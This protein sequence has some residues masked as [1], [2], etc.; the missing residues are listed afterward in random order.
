MA[1]KRQA[2]AVEHDGVLSIQ[3]L[4]DV[5]IRYDG[6]LVP[7]K[8]PPR[9]LPLLA[10]LLLHRQETV[11]RER[12][13]AQLWPDDHETDARANL[14]RHVHYLLKVLPEEGGPWLHI[15]RRT[16]SWNDTLPQWIDIDA[17]E[18]AGASEDTLDEAIELYRDDLLPTCYDDW[19]YYERERLRS[20]QI[21]NLERAIARAKQNADRPSML[22][23]AQRLLAMDPWREDVMRELLAT[24]QALGDRAGALAEFERFAQRLQD[25]LG[26]E[27]M[28]ETLAVLNDTA[29]LAPALPAQ[30]TI[31]G[32]E[33]EMERLRAWWS[34]A[35]R[36]GCSVALIGGEAGIGKSALL[37]VLAGLAAS[38]GARAF[39]GTT[40]FSESTPYEPFLVALRDAGDTSF[41][42]PRTSTR[43][44]LFELFTQRF[45]DLAQ[46]GPVLVALEDLHWA[47]Q[48]TIDLL[49]HA[50]TALADV[51]I[52]FV[53]TYRE[54]EAPRSH[55][56]RVARRRL[57]Y[58]R[59]LTHLAL[60]PLDTTS[61]STL[62]KRFESTIDDAA[63]AE[64]QKLSGGN[65]LFVLEL[66]NAR[67]SGTAAGVPASVQE[68]VGA[69]LHDLPESTRIVAQTAAI[70]GSAFDVELLSETT[71]LSESDIGTALEELLDRRFIRTSSEQREDYSFRHDLIRGAVYE[72][73]PHDMR[74]RRHFRIAAVLEQMYG[75][76]IEPYVH[77]LIY[78][79]ENAEMPAR[80][81]RYYL[82]AGRQA[83][84]GYALNTALDYFERG[85]AHAGDDVL[86]AELLLA[87]ENIHRRRVQRE[88]QEQDVEL[89]NDLLLSITDEPLRC[90]ILVRNLFLAAS[91]GNRLREKLLIAELKSRLTDE[92]HPQW[93]ATV[94][95]ADAALALRRGDLSEAEKSLAVATPIFDEIGHAPAR[96]IC[97]VL[98]GEVALM[99]GKRADA[100]I[101]N[102]RTIASDVYAPLMEALYLEFR[103]AEILDDYDA[104]LSVAQRVHEITSVDPDERTEALGRTYFDRFPAIHRRIL[105]TSAVYLG[106]LEQAAVDFAEI[107]RQTALLG[108]PEEHIA[109]DIYRGWMAMRR[110]EHA[111]ALRFFESAIEKARLAERAR[112]FID[113]S[114]YGA[115]TCYAIGEVERGLTHAREALAFIESHGIHA[116]HP[117]ALR[118]VAAGLRRL[119]RVEEAR[120]LADKAM[121]LHRAMGQETAAA[122]SAV[123][124]MAIYA[125]IG[126]TERV[127]ELFGHI[128]NVLA[129]RP[130]ALWYA[131]MPQTVVESLK[132]IG[133]D[134]DA[135][136]FLKSQERPAKTA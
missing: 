128:R 82:I 109:I 110:Q 10:Y 86:R 65:P 78:H 4:G 117:H 126:D 40:S 131:N 94:L 133:R 92:T 125:Q 70:C 31:V 73:V 39:K 58:E 63:I 16:I 32:R 2:P 134:R 25:D 46:D 72:T 28:A 101:Q 14:R 132:R 111:G 106:D 71:G 104:V 23:Y 41:T 45:R 120:P 29:P 95:M 93:R 15:D 90:E 108:N 76:N 89:L 77:A 7:F 38:E 11:S 60:G 74:I 96:V 12:V 33:S 57:S 79:F 54:E 35:T 26:V 56:L 50:V 47:D 112:E 67:H 30:S 68:L 81:V 22:K 20:L 44:E 84:Q 43:R 99:R 42:V 83:A 118:A 102:A 55:P 9:T 21:S 27:P 127:L 24:R 80:A 62:A 135:E 6:R 113:S 103:Q 1:A 100:F 116:S 49:E 53:G 17:F 19:M 105:F 119:G 61:V 64:V 130:H 107:E 85:L 115:G 97:N 5:T 37:E 66:L 13:A 114:L 98:L 91:S 123:E 51:P 34:R 121:Q 18:K 8:A 136:A 124:T 122:R 87:R 59:K 3:L 69:R 129:E 75:G 48:E 52:F 88:L 36:S